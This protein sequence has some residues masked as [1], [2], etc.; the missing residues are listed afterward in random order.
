MG[1][2][3]ALKQRALTWLSEADRAHALAAALGSVQRGRR[4]LHQH[5]DELLRALCYA[6]REDFQAVGKKLSGLKRRLRDLDKKLGHLA[7]E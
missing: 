7:G 6:P 4:A 3:H 5:Q 1:V 2:R